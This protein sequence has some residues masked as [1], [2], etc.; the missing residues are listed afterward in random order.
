MGSKIYTQQVSNGYGLLL[1]YIFLFKNVFIYMDFCIYSY[2]E[3]II[4]YKFC[5]SNN[6][7]AVCSIFAYYFPLWF[8]IALYL[9]LV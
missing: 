8:H 7:H 6:Q 2:D 9:V 4:N 5:M 1:I 3:H